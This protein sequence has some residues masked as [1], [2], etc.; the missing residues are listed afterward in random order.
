[1]IYSFR[2]GLGRKKLGRI[3]CP[4]KEKRKGG[5]LSPARHVIRKE[6][7]KKKTGVHCTPNSKGGRKLVGST[8]KERRG[9]G[10]RFFPMVV[11]KENLGGK[12]KGGRGKI[13]HRP[14]VRYVKQKRKGPGI[15]P[16]IGKKG[17]EKETSAVQVS[18]SRG[19]KE[20]KGRGRE[21]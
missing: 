17:E 5:T 6:R 13:P 10:G 20:K 11:S 21:V 1:V 9:G 8:W 19:G 18:S 12:K 3:R 7:G 4:Q 16:L 15:F 14:R 2:R